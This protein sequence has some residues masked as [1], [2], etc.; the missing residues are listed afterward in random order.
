MLAGRLVDIE[1]R[2]VPDATFWVWPDPQALDDGRSWGST[3]EGVSD[4]AGL[5]RVA[6]VAEGALGITVQVG[7]AWEDTHVRELGLVAAE[8]EVV[9]G[10]PREIEGRV[11]DAETGGPVT[12]FEIVGYK[13]IRLCGNAPPDLREDFFDEAGSFRVAG[14]AADTNR[15]EFRA[16]GYAQED[17]TTAGIRASQARD[18]VVRMWRA[19]AVR[20]RVLDRDTWEPMAG[21]AVC[22][23]FPGGGRSLWRLGF[24]GDDGSFEV[25]GIRPGSFRLCA[26]NH[27]GFESES[28]PLEGR[29]GAVFEGV[30]ILHGHGGRIEGFARS[31]AAPGMR[32]VHV[33]L[34]REGE[35]NYRSNVSPAADGAFQ[36]EGVP[37]GEY[38]VDLAFAGSGSSPG[39]TE[40]AFTQARARVRDG[41]TTTV[42]FREAPV[43]R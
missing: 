10:S 25:G 40:V 3:V 5:F 38:V 4:R 34:R 35:R 22:L 20:G 6:G 12:R 41:E 19:V 36:F 30:V 32:A 43:P 39:N 29:P 31:E 11:V 42:R 9:L 2:P 13:G 21:Q 33:W 8:V 1:G 18:V 16:P 7:P 24:T 14:L 26:G 28:G 37:P 17:F 27:F 15:L 23:A